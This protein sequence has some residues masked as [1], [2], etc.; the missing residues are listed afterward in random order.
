METRLTRLLE[1]IKAEVAYTS[2]KTG[3]KFLSENVIKAIQDV[4]RKAFLLDVDQHRAF[5]NR[6][7]SIGHDQT[8]S[9]PFIVA[10]MTELLQLKPHYCVLEIG[11]GSG[12][13][14]AILSKLVDTVYSVERNDELHRDAAKIFQ[15]LGYENIIT[16][17]GDG[18]QGWVEFSPYDAIVVTAAAP[19]IPPALVSQLKPH[20]NFVIPVGGKYAQELLLVNKDENDPL[21]SRKVLDVAFVPL[22]KGWIDH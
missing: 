4:P 1:E 20:A 9:Q 21:K 12:Y 16:K 2:S 5:E 13:Q 6:P 14:A 15:K 3:I 11:T 7:L 19:D 18:Y 17:C 10:V 8:I 22:I